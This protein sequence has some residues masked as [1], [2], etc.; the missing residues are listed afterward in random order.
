VKYGHTIYPGPKTSSAKPGQGLFV[1]TMEGNWFVVELT[2]DHF[3]ATRGISAFIKQD[4]IQGFEGG[5]LG[6]LPDYFEEFEPSRYHI[7]VEGTV[8]TKRQDGL[9]TPKLKIRHSVI[10][11][12]GLWLPGEGIKVVH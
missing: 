2:P 8:L 7:L 11:E 1:P 12:V 9:A 10:N 4:H 3:L 5:E 6:H